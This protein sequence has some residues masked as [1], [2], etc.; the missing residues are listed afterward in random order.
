MDRQT[1][2]DHLASQVTW[3]NTHGF[4]F[5]GGAT[6]DLVYETPIDSEMGLVARIAAAAGTVHAGHF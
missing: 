5:F 2:T 6:K 1:W 3:F 4:L